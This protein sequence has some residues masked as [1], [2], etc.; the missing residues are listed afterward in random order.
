MTGFESPMAPG[1]SRDD[2]RLVKARARDRATG[3]VSID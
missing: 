1:V 3:F 2:A